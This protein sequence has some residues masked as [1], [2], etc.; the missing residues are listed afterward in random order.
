ME[1]VIRLGQDNGA[2]RTVRRLENAEHVPEN[3]LY[4]RQRSPKLAKSLNPFLH[5]AGGREGTLPEVVD[6][7][8][9][10]VEMNRK[11]KLLEV[12]EWPRV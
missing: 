9:D 1:R 12:A 3:T 4:A 5:L 7:L 2:D 11:K 10:C 6:H 8:F